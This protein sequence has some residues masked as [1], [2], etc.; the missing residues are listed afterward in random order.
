LCCLATVDFSRGLRLLRICKNMPCRKGN[1]YSLIL[2]TFKFFVRCDVADKYGS[3][4]LQIL[5]NPKL[6]RVNMDN[7]SSQNCHSKLRISN[8]MKICAVLLD[9]QTDILPKD[10]MKGKRKFIYS[11]RNISEVVS[12]PNSDASHYIITRKLV[13]YILN[14]QWEP[15]SQYGG[16]FDSQDLSP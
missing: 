7:S 1:A 6:D 3:H 12:L 4:S 11:F 2:S 14:L 13:H 9:G 10:S 5:K 16:M 8:F 15:N